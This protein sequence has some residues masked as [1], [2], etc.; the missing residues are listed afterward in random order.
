MAPKRTTISTPA[1]TTTTTTTPMTNTQLKV[2]IDQ[3][4]ADAS[5]ARDAN[6]SQNGKDSH[7]SGT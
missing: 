3:G 6:R 4:V 5:A 7:D 1:I 2:L